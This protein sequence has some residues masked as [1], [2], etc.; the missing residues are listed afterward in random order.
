MYCRLAGGT[1]SR[2]VGSRKIPREQIEEKNA[3]TGGRWGLSLA[4]QIEGKLKQSLL[5]HHEDGIGV[6][7]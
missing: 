6:N 7:D 5:T 2:R 1:I 4:N 3:A